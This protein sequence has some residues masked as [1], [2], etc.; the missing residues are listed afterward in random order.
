MGLAKTW[1]NNRIEPLSGDPLSGLDCRRKRE[2]L[3]RVL[4]F[5]P[6]SQLW[7]WVLVVRESEC[8]KGWFLRHEKYHSKIQICIDGIGMTLKSQKLLH[9]QSFNTSLLTSL[10]IILNIRES[11][12]YQIR[13][14]LHMTSSPLIIAILVQLNS[15]VYLW[16]APALILHLNCLEIISD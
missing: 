7:F 10:W 4:W 11:L 5:L 13:Q 9:L 12:H 2:E 14:S 1:T 16:F 3:I 15:N 6:D 8:W